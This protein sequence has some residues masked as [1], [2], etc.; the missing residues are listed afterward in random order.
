MKRLLAFAA[1]AVLITIA[2][3]VGGVAAV[4]TLLPLPHALP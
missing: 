2:F 3:A 4:A 1:F